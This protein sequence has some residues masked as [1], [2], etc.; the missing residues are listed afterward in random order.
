M[1]DTVHSLDAKEGPSFEDGYFTAC[2][3]VVMALP[4]P[5]DFQAILNWD[6]DQIIAKAA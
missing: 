3:E 6:W 1:P 2:Y 4:P 5:F